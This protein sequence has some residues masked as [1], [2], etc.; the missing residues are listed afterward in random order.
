MRKTEEIKILLQ[1]VVEQKILSRCPNTAH[2]VVQIKI[3]I[4]AVLI[5]KI[6]YSIVYKK[7]EFSGRF[8]TVCYSIDS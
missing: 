2:L 7:N 3:R 8:S 4:T 6:A 5:A 1:S